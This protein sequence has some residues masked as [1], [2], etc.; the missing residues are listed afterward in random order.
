[1]KR[2]TLNLLTWYFDKIL[3]RKIFTYIVATSKF[4]IIKKNGDFRKLLM[5]TTTVVNTA[6][7][8]KLLNI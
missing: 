7:Y 5:K 8:I 1:M 3:N 2:F 6:L 4:D